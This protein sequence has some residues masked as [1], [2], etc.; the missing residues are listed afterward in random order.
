MKS[1]PAGLVPTLR[2]AIVVLLPVFLVLTNVRLLMTHAFPEIEYNRAGFPPDPYGFTREDRLKW[3]KL[4]VDYLLNDRGID[5]LAEMRFPDGSP[6]Y[7]ERELSHMVDVKNVV[8][9]ALAVWVISGLVIVGGAAALWATGN[10]AALRGG[11]AGGSLLTLGILGAIVLYV[12]LG[13]NQFFTQ[14][15]QVFFESGTWMFLFSDT[16]IRL[17]PLQFWFDAFTFVGAASIF[18]A[19]VIGGGALGIGNR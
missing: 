13:F 15:H 18:E 8:K 2:T 12:L 4:A 19:L 3:S 11:L 16:L 1:M 17:F 14:F 7:N 9:A 6:L 5:F 10:G